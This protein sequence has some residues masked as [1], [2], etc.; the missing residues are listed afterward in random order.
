MGG[1][2]PQIGAMIVEQD[3]KAG[4]FLSGF[5]DGWEGWV[6]GD[7]SPTFGRDDSAHPY[8]HGYYVGWNRAHIAARDGFNVQEDSWTEFNEDAL[9]A[10]L[11]K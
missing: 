11:E 6:G 8:D 1:L 4:A 3:Y 5:R 10:F 7:V 2:S 9:E